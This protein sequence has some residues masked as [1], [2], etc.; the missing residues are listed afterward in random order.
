MNTPTA[1][2]FIEKLLSLQNEKELGNVHRFFSYE[3]IES[4]F[5]GIRMN[6]LFTL[7]KTFTPMPLDEIEILLDS[8]YYE[9]RMGAVCIMDFLA[10]EKKVSIERKTELFHLYLNKHQQ[11]NN[12]DMVDRA[13]PYVV[14]GYLFDKPRDVLYELALS[15][16][17]WERRTAMVATYF[18]IRQG[19]LEDTF[20]I[21]EMLVHDKHE[22]INKSVGSWVREAGKKDR[23][24]LLAFLNRHAATMPRVTLRYAIE[25]LDKELR[26]HY[27]SLNR[28]HAA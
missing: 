11:I 19:D 7:A 16:N 12:W 23:P 22:M 10:R 15:E 28:E 3:G 25:K 14:G 8:P 24:R 27:L 9:A 1:S 20:T 26:A 18:F 5:I 21:A 17:V 2:Q 4:A 13:A 6:Q